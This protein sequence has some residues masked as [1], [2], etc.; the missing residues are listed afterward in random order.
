MSD[1]RALPREMRTRQ[2]MRANTA[3]PNQPF[4]PSRRTVPSCSRTHT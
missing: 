2:T 3:P 4:F 1:A